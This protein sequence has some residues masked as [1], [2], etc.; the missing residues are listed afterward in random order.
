V[1]AA[2]RARLEAEI[3][4]RF[5]AGDLHGAAT[6]AIEGYGPEIYGYL[7]AVM[8]DED[9]AGEV[10]A[11]MSADLW[12]DF[13]R[14]RWECSLRTWA[15]TLAR[16]RLMAYE[17]HPSRRPRRNLALSQNPEID[18]LAANVRSR[19]VSFLRTQVK[20]GVAKL[21]ERLEPDDQTLL[22]LRIDRSL[23]WREVAQIMDMAEP[24]L[25]K[26]FERLKVRLREMAR[27][28]KIL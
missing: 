26:R 1:S 17:Q 6:I 13:P 19:T 20:Q 12:K 24:A 7:I 21:R 22:I 9:G 23:S 16:H 2:E 5:D 18:Q 14:F 15:Y 25:R 8:R 4:Q 11:E 28:E 3:R 10:F 27:E